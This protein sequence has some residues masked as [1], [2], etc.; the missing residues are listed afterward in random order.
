MGV[1]LYCLRLTAKNK[2][3]KINLHA[4]FSTDAFVFNILIFDGFEPTA[5]EPPGAENRLY[6]RKHITR[7]VS[8]LMLTANLDGQND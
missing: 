8:F 1:I 7:I 3:I 6:F 5:A 2:K 4:F